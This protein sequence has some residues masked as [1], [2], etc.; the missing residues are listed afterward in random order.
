[1]HGTYNTS[2]STYHI[3]LENSFDFA[4]HQAFRT[5]IK[6]AIANKAK[7]I[8]IDFSQTEY[9]DSSALGMLMLAKNETEN[10]D[11]TIDL[12]NVHGYPL[13]M[14]GMV[15]FDKLFNIKAAE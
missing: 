13:K 8:A 4:N 7:R 3:T 14:L 1:M 2:N 9:I 15:K 6:E 5:S 10:M 11:C 12:E